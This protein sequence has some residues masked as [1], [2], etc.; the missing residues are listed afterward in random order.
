MEVARRLPPR[1]GS[2]RA[3]FCSRQRKGS[4]LPLSIP[5]L[6]AAVVFCLGFLVLV[7]VAILDL[8]ETHGLTPKGKLKR[9]DI[10][11]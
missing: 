4:A 1:I 11:Q 9:A 5:F 2:S 6:A 10:P 8:L 7:S 3:V